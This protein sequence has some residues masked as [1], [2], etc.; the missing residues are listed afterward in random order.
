MYALS[1]CCLCS[2]SRKGMDEFVF[3]SGEFFLSPSQ[4]YLHA[5]SD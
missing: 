2:S 3:A 5:S 1:T 4:R